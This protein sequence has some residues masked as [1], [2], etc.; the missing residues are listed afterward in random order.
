MISQLNGT[1][2]YKGAN[3]AVVSAFGVGYKVNLPLETLAKLKDGNE[4][5]L[6]TYLAV[7]EDSL[8]L[9][10]FETKQELDFFELLIGVPGIGPKSAMGILSVAGIE[11]LTN[12][13]ISRDT[14]YLTKISGVGK[15][16]AEKIVLELKDKIKMADGDQITMIK[17]EIDAVEALRSLGYSTREAS[18]ALRSVGKNTT[19]VSNKIKEALKY[20]SN[21]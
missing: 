6:W 8:N 18:E 2:S 3:Y 4:I 13:I 14:S 11:T 12:A 7:R 9:Y 21:K 17:E 10:G 1:I 19:D 20:L 15:K 5:K 16:S